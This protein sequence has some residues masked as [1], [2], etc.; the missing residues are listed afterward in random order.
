MNSRFHSRLALAALGVTAMLP[1]AA[2]AHRGWMLPSAT[3]VSGEEP[4]VTVDAAISNDL[5]YF[6]H[7]PMRLDNLKVFAP[8][9]KLVP[10]TNSSTGRY[11]STFDVKL[12]QAGTW[13]I[14]TLTDVVNANYKLGGENRRLRG[15][16]ESLRKELPKDAQDLSVSH[17]QNRVDVFVTSGKPTDTVL[18]PSGSGLELVAHTH[19]N[20]LVAGEEASFGL[21]FDG[22]PAVGVAVSLIPGGIRYRD[23]LGEIKLVTD[24]QG[25][26]L[27]TWPEPGMYWLNAN[28][29]PR[30]EREDNAAANNR[31]P[32]QRGTLDAPARRASY[33]ATLEVLAP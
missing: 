22:K 15:T 23:Q 32:Q 7:Q 12:D 33:T 20:D 26:F 30:G 17:S 6:E 14:S 25:R 2:D 10:A 5:F 18:K 8:D 13:R 29:P 24:Q 27:V 11:R 16:L 31:G 28:Y 19:P 4:W 1:L 3:V 9:G 21:V